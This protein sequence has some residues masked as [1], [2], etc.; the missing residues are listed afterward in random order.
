VGNA[1]GEGRQGLTGITAAAPLLF[2]VFRLLPAGN[3]FDMP[4]EEMEKIRICSESGFRP[5]M[6]CAE[7][8]FVWVPSG[9]KVEVCPWHRIIHVSADNQFRVNDKCY[10][11]S[12]MKHKKIL[13]L[14]PAME[15]FYKARSPNYTALPPVL[16][17]CESNIH[18][19]EFIYPRQWEQVFIPT[20]L[21]GTPGKVIFELVHRQRGATVFWHLNNNYL[22]ATSGIH[23]FALNPKS[24][25][26]TVNVTDN[27]G[28][29][30]SKRFFVA[31]KN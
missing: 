17:G 13:V 14:P 22:G 20:D 24:G 4:V 21:D 5:G 28:D 16:P 29:R 15:Y 18:N 26:H 19:M 1:D 3:W 27:F 12:K 23:Q 9:T 2:D 7:N 10:P 6:N 8:Q 31:D 30:L 25:W 11:L